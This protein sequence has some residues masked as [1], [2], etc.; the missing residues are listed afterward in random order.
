MAH[1]L[2][3]LRTAVSQPQLPLGL[4]EFCGQHLLHWIEVLSLTKDINAVHRVMPQLLSVMKVRFHPS[5]YLH[6]V[7][8][9]L[10]ELPELER[11]RVPHIA[12]RRTLLDQRLSDSDQPQRLTRL[13]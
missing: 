9:C 2:E 4:D 10:S 5:R 3:H 8:N 12:I 6:Q 1:W 7:L 11:R 13:P